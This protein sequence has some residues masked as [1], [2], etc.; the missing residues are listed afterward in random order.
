MEKQIILSD[1]YYKRWMRETRTCYGEDVADKINKRIKDT[2]KEEYGDKVVMLSN[3]RLL[4]LDKWTDDKDVRIF[5]EQQ[6]NA[7]NDTY[8]DIIQHMEESG[9]MYDVYLYVIG[10]DVVIARYI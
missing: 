8:V 1:E 4:R 9:G 6:K 5:M 10:F 7:S 3:L 2:L